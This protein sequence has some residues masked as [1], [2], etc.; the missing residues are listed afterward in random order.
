MKIMI[1]D[2]SLTMRRII[3]MNLKKAGY[4]DCIEAENGLMALNLLEN[5]IKPDMILLDWNMPGMSGM[6]FLNAIKLNEK[7]YDIPV[8]MVTT[9]A[10]KDKVK[11]AIQA[12]ASGYLIKPLTPE[13][14][15]KHVLERMNGIS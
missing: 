1:V 9:E 5:G 3:I 15:R 7:F 6:D 4:A 10:D 13:S 12:G 2:D 11:S 8:T 14:F